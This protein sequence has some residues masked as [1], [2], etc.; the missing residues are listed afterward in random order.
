MAKKPNEPS[1][2]NDTEERIVTD[3]G[4]VS[5]EEAK[6]QVNTVTGV[7]ASA[8]E[9]ADQVDKRNEE[10][11]EGATGSGVDSDLTE[12]GEVQGGAKNAEEL[13][14]EKGAQSAVIDGPDHDEEAQT[15]KSSSNEP[16][17]QQS[18]GGAEA[19]SST[20]TVPDVKGNANNVSEG[21]AAAPSAFSDNDL[22]GEEQEEDDF[23]SKTTTQSIDVNVQDTAEEG[24]LTSHIEDNF[25]SNTSSQT[26][27]VNVQDVNDGPTAD[28]VSFIIEEEGSLV[29]TSEYLIANSN[30]IDSDDLSIISV[31]YEGP[32]GVLQPIKGTD[33]YHFFP[34]KDFSGDLQLHYVVTDG[35][36]SATAFIDIQVT[37]VNDAPIISGPLAYSV[38][39]DGYLCLSQEQLLHNATDVEG[40]HLVAHN[41][42][43][44]EF[45]EVSDNHDGSYKIVPD[46][47]YSGPLEVLFDVSDGEYSTQQLMNIHVEAIADSPD[48]MVKDD[49]GRDL[50][51]TTL[52]TDPSNS[53]DFSIDA[54]LEDTDL[55]ETLTLA[56][57]GIPEG[58]V[59]RFDGDSVL[60]GQDNGLQ[61]FVDTPVT[62]TFEG[63]G[64]GFKNSIGYYKVDEEG[65]I[66]DVELVYSNASAVNSGGNLIPGESAFSFELQ[67]GESFNLFT[68]PN[69]A[70]AIESL[71]TALGEFVFRNDDGSPATVES[72][73]PQLVFIDDT[74]N[75]TV[76][77]GQFDDAV[78]HGGNHTQLNADDIKH[79]RS[80]INAD[81]EIVIGFEDILGGGDRDYDDFS[82]SIDMGEINQ[83]IYAGEIVVDETGITEIPTTAISD[84][85][86]IQLPQDFSGELDISVKATATEIANQDQA[87]VIQ[88]FHVDAR[89]HAPE[90]MDQA[91][92]IDEDTHYHFTLDDFSFRDQN[93]D[94]VLESITLNHLPSNGQIFL[95]GE[96]VSDGQ[97]V[98]ATDIDI[99]LLHF[100]PTDNFFGE[101]NLIFTVS[102]GKMVS[103]PHEFTINVASVND[104]VIARDDYSTS[105]SDPMIR[106]DEM[107]EYGIMQFFEDGEWRNMELGVEYPADLQVQ[108]MANVEEVREITRDIKVGSFDNNNDNSSF[109]GTTDVSDWGNI[110]GNKAVFETTDGA[111]IITSVSEGHLTAW[112]G[113]GHVGSGI[114][115]ESENGLSRNEE[116]IVKI[117]DVFVNHVTFAM[118]GLGSYFD[119]D[120]SHATEV[121]IRAYD[122]DGNIIDTQGDYR[123]SGTEYDEY[124]FTTD[125]PVDHFI[126]GTKGGDG[127]YVVQ[128]MTVSRTAADE[129]KMTTI[130]GD[131]SEVQN[132]VHLD[133]KHENAD[134]PLNLTEQLI[135]VDPSI[136]TSPFTVPEDTGFI[137]SPDE[138]LRNDFDIDGDVLTIVEVH[139]TDDTFGEVH[140]DSHGQIVFMPAPNFNGQTNFDYTV[141]DG[142]GSVDTATVYLNVKPVNDG[143]IAEDDVVGAREDIETIFASKELLANDFDLDGDK[144]YIT[145]VDTG[146]HSHGEVYLDKAGDVV[147]IPEKDFF[148]E[149]EFVYTVSDGAGSTDKASVT[150]LVTPENDPVIAKDDWA[151]AHEDQTAL[152]TAKELLANDFDLDGDKL[153]ITG[154]DTGPHS[155][156]E[157]YLDK[158]GDVVFIPEKDF[159]GEA[160][161]EYTV[162]DGAG[163]TDSAMVTVY[164][165]AENDPVIAKA[166]KVETHEDSKTV[167]TAKELLVN[168]SDV[169]KDQLYIIDV[170]TGPQTHGQAYLNEAGNVVFIPEKDFFGEA[171]FVYTVS[172]L[173]GST[174][175]ATV[176]VFVTPENDPVIAKADW[177]E[178]SEDTL[179]VFPAKALLANDF[180]MDND[181]L[182]ITEVEAGRQTHGEAYLDKAGDVVFIPEKDFFGEATFEY[183]VSDGAG[184]TDSAMVTVY[185]SAENDPVIAKADNVET[186]EDSKTVFTAKE[187][188]ANDSDVDKDQ[189]YITDVE[190]GPQAHG[191]AYLNEAGNVVF[192]PEK[193]FFGEAE[194]VYTVSDLAGSTDKATVTVLVTPEN[195]PVIAKADWVETKEDVQTVFTAKELLAN[196]FDVDKDQ[197]H[198][199]DVET[200]RQTHGEA[201][202][203]K[204]GD[205]VFIPEK[206]FV[207][208]AV[209]KYTVSDDAGSTDSAMVT[210]LVTPENDPVIAKAD[211]VETQEDSKTVFTAK[212]L[213]ANDSD[214]DK[215]QLHII[216]VE[217]GPQTH[218]QAYLDKA[219]D[220]VFIPEKDFFGEAVFKYTVS[221]GAG[222]TDKA[223]VTVLVTP[224][225]DP[226]I[227]KGDSVEAKEDHITVFSAKELVGNDFDADHDYLRIIDVHVGPETHGD[228]YVNE[229]GDVVFIPEEHYFGKAVFEY[230]VSDGAGSQDS[231]TVTIRVSEENDPVIALDDWVETKEDVQTV[232]T[233]KALLANDFD[234]DNDKLTITEVKVGPE[235]HG[236]AYVNESGDVVFTPEANYFGEAVFEY[237]VSDGRGSHDSASVNVYISEENDPVIAKD[238]SVEAKEDHITVFRANELLGNDFDADHDYLRITD[239]H[240]GPETHG[241]AYVNEFGDVVFIPEAHYFGDAV[242]EY[243]VKD[244]AGSQDTAKVTIRITEE[245]DPVIALDDWV[246]TKEDVQTVFTAKALLANDFDVDNDKLTITEVKVGPE[247]HGKAYVNES[248]DVVF[249]PE[250]NYFGEAVFE[251]TVSDGR[252]SHD[253]ASVN[254]YISEENDPV[255]AKDD[256]VEAKEDHITVFR[257]NELL[258]NDF[259]VDSEHLHITDVHVGPETHG[260]A[261]VN[262]F[263]D[264]VFIP[265]AHYFGDAVFEY[266][267]KDYAGSQDTAKVTIRI[268][269][270]NDPVIAKDDWV[271]TKEDVQTVFTAK[272]LLA[273]DFDVDN[274]KLTI[275]EVKVGPESHGKAYVNESGDVVFTPEANY[276]GEAVFEYTVSDGRGSHDS[277]SV[278]VYISPENDPVIAK[279]DQVGAK[280]DHITV[281]SAKDLVGND[282]DADNDYLRIT[283]VHVGPETHGEA[284][285]NEFG[286]V[287][288]IP[289]KDFFGKAV[290]E[291]TVSDGND[292]LDSAMVTVLVTPENDP[293]IA[294][295]DY[296]MNAEPMI[297]LDEPL[298]FGSMQYKDLQGQWADMKVGVEYSAQTEIQFTPDEDM[299]LEQSNALQLGSFD[300]N[301]ETDEFDGLASLSDW[302]T[303]EGNSLVYTQGDI[304]ITT[305][306][307]GDTLDVW[308]PNAGDPSHAGTG[309]GGAG[310][311]GTDQNEFMSIDISGM[312]ANAVTFCCGG[313]GKFF[314]KSTSGSDP[315]VIT[316]YDQE[317]NVIDIQSSYGNEDNGGGL[318]NVYSFE[319]DKPVTSFDI[320]VENDGHTGSFTVTN[321]TIENTL[322]QDLNLTTIHSDGTEE[323]NSTS[324]T[325]QSSHLNPV[326]LTEELIASTLEGGEAPITTAEDKLLR[327]SPD[328]LLKNDSDIDGDVLTIVE[329]RAT[330]ETHGEVHI[331]EHGNILFT[332]APDY[333]GPA[334]FEYTVTDGHNS[335]DTA[336]V[337]VNVSPE[338]DPVIAHHDWVEVQE[339]KTTVFKAKDLLSNDEDTDGD[340]LYIAEVFHGP[341]THGEVFLNEFGD[342]VFIPEKDFFGEAVFEYVVTDGHESFDTAKVTMKVTP[343][344]DPVI[345]H[346]DRVEI[347][348]DAITVFHA[349]DL[350]ANDFD[351]DKDQLHIID[352]NIGPNTH[353]KAYLDD[354]GDVVFI[355]ERDYSGEAVFEYVVSDEQGG[356]DKAQ[357]IVNVVPQADAP[358]ISIGNDTLQINEMLVFVNEDFESG[359]EGWNESV[360]D[361]GNMDSGNMLGAFD[362]D[363][364]HDVITKDYEV[365]HGVDKVDI[366]FD[367]HE[368]GSW[369]N[370]TFAVYIDGEPFTR[371]D[372]SHI[373]HAKEEREYENELTPLVGPNGDV[374]GQVVH[375]EDGIRANL[376]D[377]SSGWTDTRDSSQSHEFTLTVP[378]NQ[379]TGMLQLGFNAQLNG[380]ESDE[381]LG[382]DN[383]MMAA[384]VDTNQILATEDVAL[385][386]DITAMLTDI[387][388]SE[389][390]SDITF[391]DVPETITLSS[392]VNQGDGV[393]ILSQ[394]NLVGLELIPDD[395]FTGLV[396]MNISATSTEEANGDSATTTE[397]IAIMFHPVNDRPDATDDHFVGEEDRT[398]L[399]RFDT[400]LHND[401]DVDS[402]ELTVIDVNMTPDTHGHVTLTAD[403]FLFEPELDYFGIATFD[404]VVVDDDGLEDTATVTIDLAPVNDAPVIQ[405]QVYDL[406]EPIVDFNL[407]GVEGIVGE[408]QLFGDG[409]AQID[410]GVDSDQTG[411]TSYT[412]MAWVR[413]DEGSS[414]REMII[415][416]DDMGYDFSLLADNGRAAVYT[417]SGVVSLPDK[418]PTDEM[419]QLTAVYDTANDEV[420]LYVNGELTLTSPITYEGSGGNWTVGGHSS[421]EH[422]RWDDAEDF[423]GVIDE[424][425]VYDEALTDTQITTVYDLES[426]HISVDD[427]QVGNDKTLFKPSIGEDGS[428]MLH[429]ADILKHVTDVDSDVVKVTDV[430]YHHNDGELLKLEG[431]GYQF[432][433]KADWS[434][435]VE[436]DITV[437]DDGG[438]SDHGHVRFT[439]EPINDAPTAPALTIDGKEDNL[440]II[441]PKHILREVTDSDSEHVTL[442]GITIRHPENATLQLQN[443][444]MYHLLTP[445]NFNGLIE[446]GY[447]VSDGIDVTDGS[448]NVD[449]IPVN[450][451]PFI[452]GNAQFTT[453][454][455]SAFT[456][457]ESDVLNLFS[458]ID[459]EKL[460][461]SRIITQEGEEGGELVNNNDGSWT[462]NP[463]PHF[464]GTSDLQVIVSDG[465]FETALDFPVYIR[466]VADGAVI[467]TAHKGPL[468]FDEDSTGLL[469]INMSMIDSSETLCNVMITGFPVG[470]EVSDGTSLITITV[471]GQAINVTTWDIEQLALTPPENYSGN[472]V[473]TVSATTV[474][475]GEEAS[476]PASAQP[477]VSTGDFHMGSNESLLLTD[478]E[479][480]EM[481]DSFDAKGEG[482]VHM[483]SFAKPNQGEIKDNGD[484]TW[485]VTPV[486]GFMGELDIV[487]LVEQNGMLHDAQS[488]I[489]VTGDNGHN[490]APIVERIETAELE[491][492]NTL[493]F[494]K[495]DMLDQLSDKDDLEIQSVFLSSGKGMLE[496]QGDR[497]YQFIPEKGFVGEAHVAFVASD[498]ENSIESY[499]NVEVL[500]TSTETSLLMDDDGAVLIEQSHITHQLG[501]DSAETIMGVDYLEGHGTI[502]NNGDGTHHFWSDKDFDGKLNLEVSTLND[503][504]IE[505]QQ[506]LFNVPVYHLA[507]T[508]SFSEVEGLDGAAPTTEKVDEAEHVL[509]DEVSEPSENVEVSAEITA[510]PGGDVRVAMPEDIMAHHE[511]VDHVLISH[512]PED[513]IIL[514]GLPQ[515]DGDVLMAG[516]LSQS[517]GIHF[518]EAF[519]GDVDIHFQ[520]FDEYDKPIQEAGGDVN[521]KVSEEYAL[522]PRHPEIEQGIDIPREQEQSWTHADGTDTAIDVMDDSTG[523]EDHSSDKMS[524]R[525]DE[526]DNLM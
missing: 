159:F 56:V 32:H 401:Y 520:G 167:F 265:E 430:S 24:E 402:T 53:I 403:G 92:R 179:T 523:L 357:V 368:I 364:T 217:T 91:A 161:F 15:V 84:N 417:G 171:E 419:T 491:E 493:F 234:V 42:S 198:I 270:E 358:E 117:E 19:V 416:G 409:E 277:A 137:L 456:F 499:F 64:A 95:D 463:S 374:V 78:F 94:D 521:I 253:S 59:I 47:N 212:E 128:S 33:D 210:V 100:E 248:G 269:E 431:G 133:L 342:V 352:V 250:A 337:I 382:I 222:S 215:D 29:I 302:G 237:T 268:T 395:D 240:V 392:G 8:V 188:L 461:V 494:T 312:K 182:I 313:L 153:H 466:P 218:G 508:E 17:G 259:D 420:N 410:S 325:L 209:F 75:E 275:T 138:L 512:L 406:P 39:E 373:Y 298:D 99:G 290:F 235:S 488:S 307:H 440:V 115:N 398:Q 449:I 353:G 464:A 360:R 48:L 303:Q 202:L 67:E 10:L 147:F 201:Y 385:A 483:V 61:S 525:P 230:T 27:A 88:S 258:G 321:M 11:S 306:M 113:E 510:A 106:L 177:V 460:V 378:V 435:S 347:Q 503:D 232:F 309:I 421:T 229:F 120:S 428:F 170:E 330:E 241:D 176:T 122:T 393:W 45:G 242:F 438:L 437:T 206:D 434:G 150:V 252:G 486:E 197:L 187:L 388:G 396:H 379:D 105:L 81:G 375:G 165:S 186:Q 207:G 213:L 107:P 246:E 251:Y 335:F 344:N 424:A 211:K 37:E 477:S 149:A 216:D 296:T 58:A 89:E 109:S 85:I 219:G 194:F 124:H 4:R 470:F 103:L 195:D 208:E 433:P 412:L 474:D 51:G 173:A 63:E 293:V 70:S 478:A 35:I 2:I 506:V 129:V 126:L 517:I 340:K 34:N 72:V 526:D 476:Q 442:E 501:L 60:Q 181:K 151:D 57:E 169:D 225:N 239:V 74:G 273:N 132:V 308:N 439:V 317:G 125:R 163:S 333:H 139:A 141:S 1:D 168:D 386:L 93:E 495:A 371:I 345:A 22:Q 500:P 291:Y 450:D 69:G 174:D 154:V 454:E 446:L 524:Q 255:I 422:Q 377:S 367:M 498:G 238:D 43:V 490:Q 516:D 262:E 223:T 324:L 453:K 112:N 394:E 102:D 452:N 355:P 256:S 54:A 16:V 282:Y 119:K 68:I 361:S 160:V 41:L 405:G 316:A 146:P 50:D 13:S 496:E 220:V 294:R 389:H 96:P 110:E 162:S 484:G 404:Y 497:G 36:D 328:D 485:T 231:A 359:N 441:N 263:G 25:D 350:L 372:L 123:D 519:H 310:R 155:H 408:A 425:K 354:A 504:V 459:T 46:P 326:L 334:H 286:D 370:E 3:E 31:R 203:D 164:V 380:P 492:G 502:I 55:S 362:G 143:V 245:N 280:E 351:V 283:D 140:I 236:K 178:T 134:V 185:V 348:E 514:G 175:K 513:A 407:S 387:D 79:T 457:R 384:H 285:V 142:Q 511:A 369:D 436:L 38:D 52:I 397:S 184:S 455:D 111:K 183:T 249:T 338:N 383:I 156:G 135:Y 192:I 390:L 507:A 462:F 224:E 158:A 7:A 23:D 472:F 228:A 319:T 65:H 21:I 447:Q 327:L 5:P 108:F 97:V 343:E 522:D 301:I 44:G 418:L 445:P 272:E 148:G 458:D 71:N 489:A 300:E 28:D 221:D 26:I 473:L 6:N 77:K 287:V 289:E 266:T 233:A 518:G 411:E 475:Y 448:L 30:D 14:D 295:D 336:K 121:M 267:V 423:N 381:A 40:D 196:D 101:V 304:T 274:D 145:G 279:D 297:R 284:Y 429:D 323:I 190:T 281:F 426:Q 152:F 505:T 465:E 73:S 193:D 413:P 114:G 98:N 260:D 86:S 467:T 414:G 479:L 471:P 299:I 144:L 244:Y 271:E 288:F 469:G 157:V 243:T 444:G 329:V 366:R 264:V 311:F 257:A 131:G 443:D 292:S 415:C 356:T 90:S 278:N 166:D 341:H 204:A 104:P 254:V 83:Q 191:Q 226:V 200:G 18:V 118:D 189:L 180:D 480:L 487:Y 199:I 12:N 76:I 305:T 509:S 130:Q 349:N 322:V 482:D 376:N 363:N 339:D 427:I 391:S 314:S 320:R 365:P 399:L 205:V 400:V 62:V 432:I 87:S 80:D 227:A 127:T 331:D 136:E 346:H 49:E 332:P 261:Y 172:D 276:F 247:S 315:V 318:D 82:F 9:A 451:E 116:L 481:S 214:V 468:V 66:A 20:G 515:P